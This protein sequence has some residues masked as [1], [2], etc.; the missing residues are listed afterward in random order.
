M[1]TSK[2]LE[3]WPGPMEGVAKPEFVR[4]VNHLK[5]VSRWMT[6]F[7]RVSENPIPAKQIKKFLSPF[8]DGGIPVVLQLMGNNAAKLAETA[9]NALACDIAGINLNCG[10]P[11]KRVVRKTSG[12]G[13]LSDI[14]NLQKIIF[15]V[16]EQIG[17]LELSIKSRS[18]IDDYREVEDFLPKLLATG[19]IG[20]IFFHCRTVKEGYSPIG[21]PAERFRLAGEISGTIPLIIN[22]DL[23]DSQKSFSLIEIADASGAMFARNWMRDPFLLRRLENE[24]SPD[25]ET[26]R[27]LFLLELEKH[28]M[29]VGNQIET[30]KFMWGE[31]SAEFRLFLKKIAE[32]SR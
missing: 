5:L 30:A 25:P 4:C 23:D 1:T 24:K 21:D 16:K 32:V 29:S 20:K 7:L 27:K 9:K 3:F 10:C 19:A 2:K 17:D 18:G 8:V 13:T 12:G 28:E 15:C 14:D 11:S 26:G 6:P 31:N 22:G